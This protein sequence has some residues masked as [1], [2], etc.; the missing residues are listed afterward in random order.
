MNAS[1]SEHREGRTLTPLAA[2]EAALG[3]LRA[4]EIRGLEGLVR[5]HQLRAIRIAY[6]ITFDRPLSEDLVADAFVKVFERRRR[7]AA[8]WRLGCDLCG[9]VHPA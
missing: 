9:G 2:E 8:D 4:G 6:G 1:S 3:A 7:T 5:L